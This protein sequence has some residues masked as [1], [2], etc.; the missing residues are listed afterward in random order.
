V[1]A[2]AING[3]GFADPALLVPLLAGALD[4]SV[5]RVGSATLG[6]VR[7]THYRFTL[8]RK[9]ATAGF[10]RDR[11]ATYRTLFTLFE[12][13]DRVIPAEVWLDDDGLP[14]RLVVVLPGRI[15]R[16]KL[17]ELS[18]RLD[19][20]TFG[21][22]IR[23]EVPE[24]KRVEPVGRLAEMWSRQEDS[25]VQAQAERRGEREAAPR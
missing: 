1:I 24:P 7:T 10:D 16:T 5:E 17:T 6:A 15:G 12:V 13:A 21:Q 20:E 14:R 3:T 25:G 11:A 4:G 18:V 23:V 8:D 22:P 2:R 19:L 9:R